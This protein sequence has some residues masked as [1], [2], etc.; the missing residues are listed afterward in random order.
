MSKNTE[1]KTALATGA[2][3]GIGFEL[4]QTLLNNDW[5]AGSNHDTSGI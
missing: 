1:L 2:S 5:I 4:A 3:N